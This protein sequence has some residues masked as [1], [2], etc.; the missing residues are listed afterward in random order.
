MQTILKGYCKT[1]ALD[2]P[3]EDTL[4]KVSAEVRN[5]RSKCGEVK[6]ITMNLVMFCV[7]IFE[8]H[9][10]KNFFFSS[11]DALYYRTALDSGKYGL[12]T[13]FLFQ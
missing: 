10:K 2:R 1:T 7:L 9:N 3:D 8:V 13:S 4:W 5:D 11:Q 6:C 12:N